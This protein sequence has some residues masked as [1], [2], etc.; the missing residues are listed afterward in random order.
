MPANFI[1]QQVDVLLMLK[2]E[3]FFLPIVVSYNKV[4]E[5]SGISVIPLDSDI[6]TN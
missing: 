1:Q 5:G 6:D 3:S 2:A 4:G